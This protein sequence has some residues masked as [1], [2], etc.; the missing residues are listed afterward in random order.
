MFMLVVKVGVVVALMVVIM[1]VVM[2][3]V[4]KVPVEEPLMLDTV[5]HHY[6]TGLLLQVVVVE[7]SGITA[8]E[9]PGVMAVEQVEVVV[10]ARKP[11][12]E[13]RVEVLALEGVEDRVVVPAIRVVEEVIMVAVMV[14]NIIWVVV[15]GF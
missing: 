15:L 9:K 11:P 8:V 7:Q 3:Q 12:E 2:A 1:V 6:M 14:V 13:T 5:E 10:E 4:I